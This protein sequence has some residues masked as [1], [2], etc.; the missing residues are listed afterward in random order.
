MNANKFLRILKNECNKHTNCSGCTFF[1]QED[2]GTHCKIAN[3]ARDVNPLGVEFS[4]EQPTINIKNVY[5]CERKND[6]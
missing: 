1:S 6:G 2:G 3:V 5:I 4:K